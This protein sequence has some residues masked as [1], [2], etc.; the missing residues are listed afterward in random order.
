[1]MKRRTLVRCQATHGV[2]VDGDATAT[3]T[4]RVVAA[5]CADH[6]AGAMPVRL[7]RDALRRTTYGDAG[8]LRAFYLRMRWADED[9]LDDLADP[10]TGLHVVELR[11][12]ELAR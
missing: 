4:G 2:R 6:G 3:P 11:A 7:L 8:H 5:W 9:L 1:M 10:T 12:V